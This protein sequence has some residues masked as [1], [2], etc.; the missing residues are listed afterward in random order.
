MLTR[1]RVTWPIYDLKILV[2]SC[3]LANSFDLQVYQAQ[4]QYSNI[5]QIIY[6][7]VVGPNW[8][9]SEL[10]DGRQTPKWED[11][12]NVDIIYF[13]LTCDVIGDP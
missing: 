13:D 4:G 7:R 6:S 3:D 9:H 11:V 5:T 12:P 1:K 8:A 10:S 2:T